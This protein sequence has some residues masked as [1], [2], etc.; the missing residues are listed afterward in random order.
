MSK[1]EK[2]RV[3]AALTLA[4]NG[5]PPTSSPIP[6]T[7]PAEVPA[8][9]GP[10]AAPKEERLRTSITLLLSTHRR[11]RLIALQEDKGLN[12]IMLEALADYLKGRGASPKVDVSTQRCP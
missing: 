8:Q 11:L 4:Q 7:A 1:K 3:L 9:H 10:R 12:D 6:A 5:T 2:R